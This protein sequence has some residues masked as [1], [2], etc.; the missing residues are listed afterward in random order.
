MRLEQLYCN[1]E[2]FKF[3]TDWAKNWLDCDDIFVP[4]FP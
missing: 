3:P 1:Q 2:S 4:I